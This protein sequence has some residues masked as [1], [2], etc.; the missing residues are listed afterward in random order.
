MITELDVHHLLYRF[1]V[2]RNYRG[3]DYVAYAIWLAAQDVTRMQLITKCIYPDV[4][5]HFG[6]QPHSVERDIRT[7]IHHIWEHDPESFYLVTGLRLRKMP[8]NARFIAMLADFLIRQDKWRN[9]EFA[10]NL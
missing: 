9:R 8:T 2:T 5:K 6:I 1:C 10:C 4:A 7:L 3:T